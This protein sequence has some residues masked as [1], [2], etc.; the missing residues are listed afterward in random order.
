MFEWQVAK[1]SSMVTTALSAVSPN[2][3]HKRKTDDLKY[4]YQDG[5]K[6]YGYYFGEIKDDDSQRE[7]VSH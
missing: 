2:T 5:N 1:A 7:L 4:G 3:R 6:D